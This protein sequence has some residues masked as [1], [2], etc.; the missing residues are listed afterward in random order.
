MVFGL[1][2]KEK[3]LKRAQKKAL[4]KLAQSQDRWPAMQRLANAGDDE[5][6]YT[7][8]K[9]FSFQSTKQVEDLDEKDWVVQAVMAK[10]PA[11]LPA[12]ERYLLDAEGISYPLRILE[13]VATPEQAAAIVDKVLDKELPGYT[14][15]PAKKI[16]LINWLGEYQQMSAEEM[17][18]RVAPYV[19]D[20]DENVR[21]AAVE[22]IGLR[23]KECAAEAMVT[24]LLDPEEESR[25][26]KLRIAEVLAEA[27]MDLGG[28]HQ[29]VAELFESVLPEFKLHRN[30]LVKKTA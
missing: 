6:L 7:L 8:L 27:D 20:Y 26:L 17:C 5:C 1:F 9:R 14:R 18:R 29:E 11:A 24:R 21:F 23:P 15:D 25:R 30:K 10:G 28:R 19:G 4:N 3:A 2:S 16:D 12:I 22:S 13:G